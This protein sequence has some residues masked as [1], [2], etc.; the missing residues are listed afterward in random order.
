MTYSNLVTPMVSLNFYEAFG[1]AI[2][3][4]SKDQ[5]GI[6]SNHVKLCKETKKRLRYWG[7]LDSTPIWQQMLDIDEDKDVI[8]L[9]ADYLD[10]VASLLSKN[11]YQ[12]DN[13]NCN[14][15]PTWCIED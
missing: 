4:L 2:F 8:V 1:L 6:L 15:T 9:N 10:S 13:Q 14:L 5:L 11:N 7:G 12:N 3:K